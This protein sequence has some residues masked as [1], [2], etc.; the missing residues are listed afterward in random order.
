MTSKVVDATHVALST[1]D[2]ASIYSVSGEIGK[3][4]AT[5]LGSR[6]LIGWRVSFRKS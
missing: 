6:L 2:T 3:L 1:G 5:I 4:Q